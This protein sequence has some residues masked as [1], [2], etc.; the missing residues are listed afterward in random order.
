[1]CECFARMCV[2]VHCVCLVPMEV[3]GGRLIPRTRMVV[4]QQGVLETEP[5]SFVRA[6]SALNW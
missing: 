5:R 2:Y 4:N 3:R 6:V 1:M